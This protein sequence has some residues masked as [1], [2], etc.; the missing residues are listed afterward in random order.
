MSI[1]NRKSVV[2]KILGSGATFYLSKPLSLNDLKNLWQYAIAGKKDKCVFEEF[3]PNY[4]QSLEDL[5]GGYVNSA[6]ASIAN[7]ENEKNKYK[8]RKGLEMIKGD[9]YEGT[10][11]ASKKKTKI[12]WSNS[13]HK[14]FLMAIRHIGFE[15]AVPKKIVELMNVPGLTREHVASHLQKYR[16]FLKKVAEIGTLEGLSERVLRSTFA[17]E[18][19]H[20]FLRNLQ[21]KIPNLEHQLRTM[22]RSRYGSRNAA[23]SNAAPN[24][25]SNQVP[26]QYPSL[27]ASRTNSL[28]PRIP[29]GQP[30]IA[31]YNVLAHLQNQEASKRNQLGFGQSRLLTGKANFFQSPV[32]GYR[33]NLHQG[34]QAHFAGSNFPTYGLVNARNGLAGGSNRTEMYP[35]QT[36]TNLGGQSS[37]SKLPLNT[38]YYPSSNY[39]GNQVNNRAALAR[40]GQAGLNNNIGVQN[41]SNNGYGLINGFQVGNSSYTVQGGSSSFAAIQ[42]TFHQFPP[43][44]HKVNQQENISRLP[45]VAQT[46][47]VPEKVGGGQDSTITLVND[48]STFN[49]DLSLDLVEL[50]LLHDSN[51]PDSEEFDM[52]LLEALFGTEANLKG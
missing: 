44:L 2:S 27:E 30:S 22:F 25:A 48:A 32:L 12:V 45:P 17:S 6:E 28:Q 10:S 37:G 52:E 50:F 14:R 20:L 16:I 31:P 39:P 41:V 3:A 42:S 36:Q 8:K 13:L 21:K 18:L 7:E 19:S 29:Y 47:H 1:D 40:T 11:M 34:N 33:N 9:Q 35:Q 43:A 46:Q 38:V 26:C 23:P 24:S 51:N 15:R 5:S 49:K 4:L